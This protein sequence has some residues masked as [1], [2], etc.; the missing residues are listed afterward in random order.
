MEILKGNIKR[1]GIPE[2][3]DGKAAERITELLVS[4]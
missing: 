4:N 2:F 3:W 1:G